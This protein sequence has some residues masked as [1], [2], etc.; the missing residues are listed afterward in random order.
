ME[1]INNILEML[2]EKIKQEDYDPEPE[3]EE[4]VKK[5]PKKTEAQIFDIPKK[6]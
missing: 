4:V 2:Q 1:S 5:K 6:K 3:V